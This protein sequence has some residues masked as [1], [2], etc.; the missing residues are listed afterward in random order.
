MFI[1]YPELHRRDATF[2]LRATRGSPSRSTSRNFTQINTAERI[3]TK[4][5]MPQFDFF[6]SFLH[7]TKRRK[8]LSH[9]TIV[10]DKTRKLLNV[11]ITNNIFDNKDLLKPDLQ[12]VWSPYTSRLTC[13]QHYFPL[14]M[15]RKEE[16]GSRDTTHI[17][18]T[19]SYK[20]KDKRRHEQG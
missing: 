14:F 6:L 15:L 18:V 4:T 9:L 20:E 8:R 1:E 7:S 10:D 12:G 2:N 3:V 13:S 17:H 5:I 11:N 19:S 16:F